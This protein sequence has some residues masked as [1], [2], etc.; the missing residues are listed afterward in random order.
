MFQRDGAVAGQMWAWQSDRSGRVDG[1]HVEA[2]DLEQ[3]T[4]APWALVSS[5]LKWGHAIPFAFC[6][7]QLVSTPKDH[8]QEGMA[9]YIFFWGEAFS[10]E[11]KFT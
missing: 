3:V 6:L 7:G 4:D 1:C 8:G 9:G 5:P 10:L 2:C 11:V